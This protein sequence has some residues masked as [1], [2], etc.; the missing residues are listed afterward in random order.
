MKALV[1]KEID[2]YPEIEMVDNPTTSCD[3]EILAF[4]NA[5]SLNHRDL[6][7]VKGQ[8]PGIV[9]PS[10]LGSD[11]C[12]RIGDEN[13]LINPN[14]DWGE[15]DRFQSKAYNILGLPRSGTF[16]EQIVVKKDR[17]HPK[18][19]HLNNEE[20]S[21]IPLAGLTAWRA[22]VTKCQIKENDTVLINGIGGGVALFAFQ[23]ALALG[24]SVFVTSSSDEKIEKAIAMGAKGGVN[25]KYPDWDK[26]IIAL[27]NG[28]DAVIDSAAGDGFNKLVKISKPGGNICFYGGTQ[29]NINGLNP[30]NIFWKQLTI[31]GST[32]GT[33]KEF[34]TMLSF[35]DLHKIRPVVESIFPFEDAHKA[36]ET[37]NTGSQ[38]GKIVLK[39]S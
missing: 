30:Q 34:E 2:K 24:A 23:F 32:M 31:H 33:D 39:I 38:F 22:A 4:V 35:I 15:S 14:N 5:A 12:V 17:L 13:F 25:Y 27:S 36:F 7:I 21:A 26:K 8:Y 9:F 28:F 1:F 6:W 3:S 29:G 19:L 18:P 16:A 10:I 11:G 20:A 37:M